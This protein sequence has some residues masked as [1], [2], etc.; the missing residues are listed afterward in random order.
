MG[1]VRG[2]GG[3]ARAHAAAGDGRPHPGGK[4]A[5]TGRGER[6]GRGLDDDGRRGP[7]GVRGVVIPEARPLLIPRAQEV[8]GSRRSIPVDAGGR[9]RTCGP[10]RDRILSPAPLAGLGYPRARRTRSF[11][12]TATLAARE[13]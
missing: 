2:A 12:V 11:L 3:P 7:S 8:R 4:A 5:G 9:I 10:L 13:G 1:E 6:Q